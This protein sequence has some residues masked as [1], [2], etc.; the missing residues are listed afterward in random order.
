MEEENNI[1]TFGFLTSSSILHAGLALL[2]VYYAGD[3][4]EKIRPLPTTEIEILGTGDGGQTAPIVADDVVEKQ[5]TQMPQ[6]AAP[7]SPKPEPVTQAA[8]VT[9]PA[10]EIETSPVV[11]AKSLPAKPKSAQKPAS[12]KAVPTANIAASPMTA[13]SEELDEAPAIPVARYEDNMADDDLSEVAKNER[14]EHSNQVAAAAADMDAAEAEVANQKTEMLAAVE[15]QNQ[16]EDEKMA[17]LVAE[18]KKAAMIAGQKAEQA[19][20]A[21]AQAAAQARAEAAAAAKAAQAQAAAVAAQ[22]QQKGTGTGGGTN[23]TGSSN[24]RGIQDLKQVIGNKKPEYDKE[25]RFNGR[26]GQVIFQA[27]VTPEGA[28]QDFQLLQS[29]G[30]KTLDLKTLKALRAWKFHPGQEGIVEIPFKWDLVGGAQEMPTSLRRK[31]GRT[32]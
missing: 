5:A 24:V 31:V 22:S 15:K 21:E 30:H 14:S 3:I 17:A 23:E 26:Q 7:T 12:Q 32:D 20:I 11:V 19:R 8:T 4:M 13:V 10:P 16:E 28:L 25:D 29:S 2:V 18:K 6:A 9:T 1:R 27:Y